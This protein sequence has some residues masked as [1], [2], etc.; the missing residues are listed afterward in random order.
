MNYKTIIIIILLSLISFDCCNTNKT[1]EY[2]KLESIDNLI[3]EDNYE[4]ANAIFESIDIQ[5]INNNELEAYYNMIYTRINDINKQPADIDKINSSI[6]YYKRKKNNIKTAY[7]Y[8][9]KGN[10][11]LNSN[12]DSTIWNYKE[13]EYYASMANDPK[14]QYYIYWNIA[15]INGNIG[16]PQLA[17]EYKKKQY[18]IS[19]EMGT[20]YH[21]EAL[22]NLASSYNRLKMYDSAQI[23]CHQIKNPDD[24]SQGLKPYYY[25]LMGEL[26]LSNNKDQ[27]IE[28]FEKS[29]KY[30]FFEKGY[31]NLSK[32]YYEN[33]RKDEAEILIQ[34]VIDSSCYEVQIDVLEFLYNQAIADNNITYALELSNRIRY[35]MDSIKTRESKRNIIKTQN[36]YDNI[37]KGNIHKHQLAVITFIIILIITIA[38][39]VSTALLYRN[40]SQQKQMM[41]N[42][43]KIIGLEKEIAYLEQQSIDSDQYKKLNEELNKLQCNTQKAEKLLDDINH[44]SPTITWNKNDFNT[45][46]ELFLSRNKEFAQTITS[47]YHNLTINDKILLILEHIGK[48]DTEIC[49]ILGVSSVTI[50]VRRS[51]LVSK[52]Q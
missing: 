50:R 31:K 23:C 35:T 51:R 11:F 49:A 18:N 21:D 6:E 32:L 46:A 40:V 7:C 30:R 10:Q 34:K 48:S 24:L 26:C 52:Q 39:I 17:L 38:I 25:N 8:L 41:E 47:K 5:N 20:Q 4:A 13:A 22:L 27:A 42:N 36:H 1:E 16:D 45:F 3:N 29:I 15:S 19:M 43:L 28:Y 14:L 9:Y 44:N 2:A 37:L 12:A 33:G